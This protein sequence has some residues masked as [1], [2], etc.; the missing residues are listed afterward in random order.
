[1]K[2][3]IKWMS[4]GQA[5]QFV[6]WG[7]RYY[8]EWENSFHVPASCLWNGNRVSI[9]CPLQLMID[10]GSLKMDLMFSALEINFEV[11]GETEGSSYWVKI[12]SFG[13]LHELGKSFI[14]N[15]TVEER[16]QSLVIQNKETI[17]RRDSTVCAFEISSSTNHSQSSFTK[18]VCVAMNLNR[19]ST[20]LGAVNENIGQGHTWRVST[21][22]GRS[23]DGRTTNVDSH[24]NVLTSGCCQ[25]GNRHTKGDKELNWGINSEEKVV[26][27]IVKG[28]QSILEDV[29]VTGGGEVGSLQTVS[30]N[31]FRSFDQGEDLASAGTRGD[32]RLVSRVVDSL[33]ERFTTAVL[34]VP[35]D[36]N[37]STFADRV[38]F[39]GNRSGHVV[40]FGFAAVS[41]WEFSFEFVL[42]SKPLAETTPNDNVVGDQFT[43]IVQEQVLWN[44]G[45]SREEVNTA[46]TMQ[47]LT[48]RSSV[49]LASFRDIGRP[50]EGSR[51]IQGSRWVRG[52]CQTSPVHVV[53][54]CAFTALFFNGLAEET[55]TSVA[56]QIGPFTAN[57][58][59]VK[60]DGM[61]R[62][63]TKTGT[64]WGRTHN[65]ILDSSLFGNHIVGEDGVGVFDVMFVETNVAFGCQDTVGSVGQSFV[66]AFRSADGC[67][68]R[69]HISENIGSRGTSGVVNEWKRRIGL[70]G[71]RELVGAS[72]GINGLHQLHLLFGRIA[73]REDF[74]TILASGTGIFG[75]G[76][77]DGHGRLLASLAAALLAAGFDR[78]GQE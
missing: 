3:I 62:E 32:H 8:M 7:E 71:S 14:G 70:E 5:T 77:L 11:G 51:Q 24:T 49:S 38:V 55:A 21:K 23:I 63:R 67:K 29:H 54:S 6:K 57:R 42:T 35:L 2:C 13:G 10:E 36:G 18:D 30:I 28:K 33:G 72:F 31:V 26:C 47:T 56:L 39:R 64:A 74:S 9:W 40:E 50:G 48:G 76:W 45:R 65:D 60:V 61:L 17:L 19:S 37:G 34:E 4:P 1:M 44:I 58:L 52:T 15:G 66:N 68:V 16:V 46:N 43:I 22:D 73:R 59:G 12:G 20:V 69:R 41:P 53:I 27:D 75:R 78:S 25:L